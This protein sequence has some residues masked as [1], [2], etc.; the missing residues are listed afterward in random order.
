MPRLPHAVVI[1]GGARIGRVRQRHG[2]VEVDLGVSFRR[3]DG[4]AGGRC[5]RRHRRRDGSVRVALV[6]VQD[7]VVHLGLFF[8]FGMGRAAGAAEVGVAVLGAF[9]LSVRRGRSPGHALAAAGAPG[10]LPVR[11]DVHIEVL[12]L[13]VFFSRLLLFLF[14]EIVQLGVVGVEVHALSAAR[15][16]ARAERHHAVHVRVLVLARLRRAAPV[17]IAGAAHRS[18]HVLVHDAH[19]VEARR[20]LL[21]LLLQ[22]GHLIVHVVGLAGR[23]RPPA[24]S[25]ETAA[26]RIPAGGSQRRR[27][28]RLKSD[29]TRPTNAYVSPRRR[30]PTT[31]T[32][33][34]LG[35]YRGRGRLRIHVLVCRDGLKIPKRVHGRTR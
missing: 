9:E 1:E 25:P 13:F 2:L 11:F 10:V 23:I 4:R 21:L 30:S 19:A 26:S 35:S 12:L 32:L 17:Q 5:R 8:G 27:P 34:P 33:I 3:L 14:Q 16:V 29:M 22:F 18:V 15:Q 6:E 24:R 20:R 28:V 31:T 7:S